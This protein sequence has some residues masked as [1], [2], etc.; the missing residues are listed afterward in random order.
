MICNLP[1][2]GDRQIV[3][4]YAF[5]DALCVAHW[6]F[7]I[8]SVLEDIVRAALDH[9]G[10]ILVG[11]DPAGAQAFIAQLDPDAPIGFVAGQ[12]DTPWVR[13]H[14]PIAVRVG[15]R[16]DWVLARR[17]EGDRKH[18][19]ELFQ[20]IL[21]APPEQTDQCVAHGNLVGGDGGFAVSTAAVLIENGITRPQPLR[22]TARQLGIETWVILRPFADDPSAHTDSMV[23]FLAPGVAAVCMRTD[24][25]D[26]TDV[27]GQMREMLQRARPDLRLLEV[28]VCS[29][30]DSFSSPLNWIQL[31]THLI[32]PEFGPQ[33]TADF[34]AVEAAGYQINRVAA[35]LSG[36]GGAFHCLSASVFT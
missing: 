14:S 34:H 13:D 22:E 25:P 28:P 11:P 26:M 20:R 4:D 8:Q 5:P 21:A 31:G 36:L 29:R 33:I 16:I 7:E 10:V 15:D 24:R 3:A 30:A 23:R 18:D 17:P 32:V 19:P 27:S 35:P 1:S 6:Q 2:P 9:V 12:I